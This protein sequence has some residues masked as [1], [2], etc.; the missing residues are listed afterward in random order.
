M[1]VFDKAFNK[2]TPAG[3]FTDAAIPATFAPY[4][5]QNIPT[6]AGVT[7]IY[8]AYAQQN[9]AKTAAV[10]GAGLCSLRYST[11]PEISSRH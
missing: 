5:I 7:Q 3:S 1:D 9:A 4:G 8:V 6:S 2:V 11:R 10:T